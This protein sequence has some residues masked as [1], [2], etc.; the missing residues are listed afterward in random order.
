M[1]IGANSS[2]AQI[3]PSF[4]AQVEQSTL[5]T[6][7]QLA[8]PATQGNI[9]ESSSAQTEGFVSSGTTQNQRGLSA[10]HLQLGQSGPNLQTQVENALGRQ[11][12]GFGKGEEFLRFGPPLDM[13]GMTPLKLP[14]LFAFLSGGIGSGE[15]TF[16][17]DYPERTAFV[18]HSNQEFFL[19][20]KSPQQGGENLW[21]GPFDLN[22]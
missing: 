7:S 6:T 10:L 15:Q 12:V 16:Q 21:F 20:V 2:K 18:D 9:F 1:K 3:Q 8:S 13:V 11:E 17:M 14:Q 5:P 4:S 19:N 22:K